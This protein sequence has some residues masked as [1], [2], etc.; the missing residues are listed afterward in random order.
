MTWQHQ[1]SMMTWQ[2]HRSMTADEFETA[3][4]QLGISRAAAARLTGYS[5]RQLARMANDQ[6]RVPTVL[7]LLLWSMIYHNET[8]IVPPRVPGAY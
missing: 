3:L 7:A 8:P 5:E 6:V 4:N 2:H 1:R